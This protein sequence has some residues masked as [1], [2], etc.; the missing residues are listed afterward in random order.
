M[1]GAD[2][3]G[4]APLVCCRKACQKAKRR[5]GVQCFWVFLDHFHQ[6]CRLAFLPGRRHNSMRAWSSAA[7]VPS[8]IPRK[9]W[10]CAFF[11]LPALLGRRWPAAAQRRPPKSWLIRVRLLVP[12]PPAWTRRHM[13]G[14]AEAVSSGR[15]VVLTDLQSSIDCQ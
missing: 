8:E 11:M 1:I 5:R 9:P 6:L 12:A 3:N 7:L 13:L 10:P 4:L 14:P 15:G 2:R